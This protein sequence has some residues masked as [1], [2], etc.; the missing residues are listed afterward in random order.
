M[1]DFL[2]KPASSVSQ[3]PI[4]ATSS[5][6]TE[7]RSSLSSDIPSYHSQPLDHENENVPHKTSPSFISVD[8]PLMNDE[9]YVSPIMPEK[10]RLA[11]ERRLSVSSSD[12]CSD[13]DPLI[14]PKTGKAAAVNKSK[15]DSFETPLSIDELA[16]LQQA[17]DLALSS[18]GELPTSKP[19]VTDK[20]GFP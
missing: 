3:E 15:N 10:K 2:L 9:E 20:E 6:L 17:T 18:S 11:T 12:S 16:G 13:T 4:V 14:K 8:H 7:D 1:V 5:A 19:E